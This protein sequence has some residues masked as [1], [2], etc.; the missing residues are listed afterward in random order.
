PYY[1]QFD[2]SILSLQPTPVF[3]DRI[4]DLPDPGCMLSIMYHILQIMRADLLLVN[5]I[6]VAIAMRIIIT[7]LVI[8]IVNIVVVLV[9]TTLVIIVVIVI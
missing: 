6:F 9:V 1:C 8:R 3:A 5:S 7:V 4:R 2:Y